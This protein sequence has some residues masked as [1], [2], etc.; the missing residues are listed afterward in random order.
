MS[1]QARYKK[2][3]AKTSALY[4][5]LE[6]HRFMKE[7]A[8]VGDIDLRRRVIANVFDA[9]GNYAT[10][11]CKLVGLCKTYMGLTFVV[12]PYRPNGKPYKQ[13]QWV[14]AS[15]FRGNV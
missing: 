1:L 4:E 10:R 15:D 6:G 14:R 2:Q 12:Q 5:A 11:E 7:L 13:K 3:Q 9:R 8:A